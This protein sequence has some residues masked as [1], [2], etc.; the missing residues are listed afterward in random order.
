[1]SVASQTDYAP[2]NAQ[3]RAVLGPI[4]FGD[5]AQLALWGVLVTL[6]GHFIASPQWSRFS[7]TLRGIVIAVLI[8]TTMSSCISLND[9]FYYGTLVENDWT[10]VLKGT[11]P[12]AIEPLMV[13]IIA[14]VVQVLL[15]LRASN[16]IERAAFKWAYIA[17]V[18]VTISME[19]V[20]CSIT[21]YYC[22]IF[23]QNPDT[24]T[25]RNISI[26]WSQAITAWMLLEAFIDI[27][28]SGS[29]ILILRTRLGWGSNRSESYLRLIVKLTLQSALLTSVFAVV[30]AILEIRY[31]GPDLETEDI[32]AAFLCP[33]PAIY[34]ISLF[35]TL[36]IPEKSRRSDEV[37]VYLRPVKNSEDLPLPKFEGGSDTAV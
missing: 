28:I 31:P 7:P 20:M 17:F 8:L 35:T 14:A 36:A 1:M 37:N 30:T 16:V 18:G 26:G 25:E 13:G 10:T 27:W 34:A 3:M 21:T 9:L 22:L 4:L 2:T 32:Y 29:Y 12:E 19:L 5:M 11:V 15:M 33:Q 6:A 23:Y 24:Y